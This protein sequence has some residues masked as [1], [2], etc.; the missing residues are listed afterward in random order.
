[1]ATQDHIMVQVDLPMEIWI[2]IRD[3]IEQTVT[4]KGREGTQMLLSIFDA[5]D[6]AGVHLPVPEEVTESTDN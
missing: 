3:V 2:V 1:V 4:A 6:A 5:F